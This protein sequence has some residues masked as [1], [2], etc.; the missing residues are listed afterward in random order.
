MWQNCPNHPLTGP[1]V[2]SE[3]Q[4]STEQQMKQWM[5]FSYKLDQ[6]QYTITGCFYCL[7]CPSALLYL[8]KRWLTEPPTIDHH[9][10]DTKPSNKAKLPERLSLW[11]RP[12]TLVLTDTPDLPP[13]NQSHV[14]T[15]SDSI[16]LCLS[17]AAGQHQRG[18]LL[19]DSLS[20]GIFSRRSES[21]NRGM[22]C[23]TAEAY[24]LTALSAWADPTCRS[25]CRSHR[26]SCLGRGERR[27]REVSV[28][29]W[30]I[31]II[32]DDVVDTRVRPIWRYE[33]QYYWTDIAN[34]LYSVT[35]NVSV[36][37]V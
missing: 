14:T 2:T 25:F 12:P 24:L 21:V 3:F 10:A 22:F 11:R 32:K 27:E 29:S 13:T 4:H 33:G 20:F 35:L 23:F 28:T 9:S 36:S 17:A 37:M 6:A 34:S 19:P 7:L 16:P 26:F 1:V 31:W 30:N 8:T 15:R 5:P 18:E